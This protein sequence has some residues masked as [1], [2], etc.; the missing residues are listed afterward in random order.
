[1]TVTGITA[2]CRMMITWLSPKNRICDGSWWQWSIWFWGQ[3]ESMTESGCVAPRVS[4]PVVDS[5]A[6]ASTEGNYIS[7]TYQL[8]HLISERLK[9]TWKKMNRRRLHQI[10]GEFYNHQTADGLAFR[11]KHGKQHQDHATTVSGNVCTF[12]KCPLMLLAMRNT[13]EAG[14]EVLFV[15]AAQGT[16]RYHMQ[17]PEHQTQVS[18]ERCCWEP[19]TGISGMYDPT[20]SAKGENRL[21]SHQSR[22]RRMYREFISQEVRYTALNRQLWCRKSGGNLW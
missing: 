18:H 4:C 1:M 17:I 14:Q 2:Y 20:K 5:F 15:R 10:A 7:L 8:K 6:F 22:L 21:L 9:E 3:G 13:S 19:D 16:A 11:L 12:R